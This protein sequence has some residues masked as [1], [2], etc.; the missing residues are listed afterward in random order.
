MDKIVVIGP[1]PPP[2]HGMAK[3]L[4]L[5]FDSLQL[6]HAEVSALDISP[7]RLDRGFLYHFAK[8]KKF[9]LAWFKL[10][11]FLLTKKVKSA[12]IPPDGGF[13]LVYT[14]SFVA[15]ISIF[16]RPL[17][18]HHRSFAY[19]NNKSSF[20]SCICSINYNIT[21]VFLCGCM[22][23]RFQAMYG[24]IKNLAIVSNATHV[25]IPKVIDISCNEVISI[26][27]MSNI[28][29]EKG[30]GRF[31][32]LVETLTNAGITLKAYIAGPFDSLEVENSV[33]DLISNSHYINYIGPVYNE[34]K[35]KFFQSL[36]C[37]VFPTFYRNEAQPNVLFEAMSFGNLIVTSDIACIAEDFKSEFSVIHAANDDWVEVVAAD[38]CLLMKD[39]NKLLDKRKKSFEMLRRYKELSDESHNR[40]IKYI[41]EI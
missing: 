25:K 24:G 4:K 41:L 20:M 2:V 15:L 40:L 29:F 9:L 18:M 12:Y 27:F 38:L 37:F 36:D 13:G 26:G 31:I 17:I 23:K 1:F 10:L 7:G 22:A 28:G 39:K 8:F 34:E 35:D 21:H 33:K 19:I 14:F 6:S 3:N 11:Y 5:M 32:E 16:N 30:I